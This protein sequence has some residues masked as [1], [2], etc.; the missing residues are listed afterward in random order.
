MQD[1]FRSGAV[2]FIDWLNLKFHLYFRPLKK[3]DR[4]DT[5]ERAVRNPN[6][7]NGRNNVDE[8]FMF[9]LLDAVARIHS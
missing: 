5:Q 2:G 4:G 6:A 1:A 9:S 7:V 3:Y 8:N